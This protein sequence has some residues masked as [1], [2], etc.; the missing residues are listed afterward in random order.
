MSEEQKPEDSGIKFRVNGQDDPVM[1]LTSEGFIY[2]G[3]VVQD[4][5]EA[6]KLFVAWL[7]T[8]NVEPK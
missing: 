1:V 7:K 8:A 3:E 6:Y 5:G 2:K 4:A